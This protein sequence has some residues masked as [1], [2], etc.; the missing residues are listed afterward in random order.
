MWTQNK[1]LI[2]ITKY[3]AALK[4]KMGVIAS[5]LVKIKANT[6]YMLMKI[7]LMGLFLQQHSMLNDFTRR[8]MSQISIQM[9]NLKKWAQTISLSR[10]SN[11]TILIYKNQDKDYLSHGYKDNLGLLLTPKSNFR[12]PITNS[13]L[14]QNQ[15]EKVGLLQRNYRKS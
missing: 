10:N 2:F 4:E 9:R 15:K 13:I 11:N 1:L 12:L 8:L 14:T 6:K 7:V 5:A 3:I